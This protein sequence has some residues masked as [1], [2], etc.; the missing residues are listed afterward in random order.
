MDKKSRHLPKVLQVFA[1]ALGAAV[2]GHTLLI[3]EEFGR[4]YCSGFIFN[5][6][7]RMLIMNY[8]LKDKVI[9]DDFN[10]E[11]PSDVVV[12]KFQN[13]IDKK[14]KLDAEKLVKDIPSVLMI[15]GGIK[16][17]ALEIHTNKQVL[18]I[19][20]DTKY[21]KGFIEVP[22]RS[23]ALQS[24]LLSTQ[25]LLFEQM[26]TAP[27]QK[28]VDEIMTNV[29]DEVFKLFF[30]RVKAEELICRLLMELLKREETRIYPLMDI[31]VEHIYKVRERILK[32][33]DTPPV[34]AELAAFANVST[35]KLKYLFKQIFGDSIYNYYQRFRMQEAAR[36]LREEKLSVADAGYRLG[37]SNLSHFSR[38]F[39][40]HLGEK[41]KKYSGAG[42]DYPN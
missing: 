5:A 16:A 33:L 39:E 28:I 34:I 21:L 41:P 18:N 27:L 1:E 2:S 10:F 24:L 4:G 22:E 7:I 14:E 9:V 20:V 12:F 31:D 6:H 26:I 8:E 19:E 13:V 29:V 38:L 25:P 36:L 40:S 11:I 17:D 3:P 42:S 15:T 32:N 35:S 37:F 23:A 30:L